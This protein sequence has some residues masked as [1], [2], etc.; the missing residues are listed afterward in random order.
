[1][2]FTLVT[3]KTCQI[4]FCPLFWLTLSYLCSQFLNNFFPAIFEFCSFFYG[5]RYP[6]GKSNLINS[7]S[8]STS[9]LPHPLGHSIHMLA[10]PDR[11]NT[12]TPGC[13]NLC[14]HSSPPHPSSWHHV[15]SGTAVFNLHMRPVHTSTYLLRLLT[16]SSAG[17]GLY[18]EKRTGRARE[19]GCS[20]PFSWWCP[21]HRGNATPVLGEWGWCSWSSFV[22]LFPWRTSVY[23]TFGA[24]IT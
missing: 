6:L 7:T 11:A 22:L 16:T 9:R 2:V 14:T 24:W 12:S 1:M 19:E 4:C 17:K 20:H 23:I 21:S 13:W 5:S 18:R 3:R 15:D 10:L 8:L